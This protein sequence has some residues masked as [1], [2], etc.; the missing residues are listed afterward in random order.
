M[1]WPFNGHAKLKRAWR[2]APQPTH[3]AKRAHMNRSMIRL[4]FLFL[5]A[6]LA[7]P[8]H[9][10]TTTTANDLERS[11]VGCW[12]GQLQYRDYKSGKTYALPLRTEIS[13]INDGV[14]FLKQSVFDEG[15]NRPQV[16]ITTL[17]M[18]NKSGTAITTTGYRAGQDVETDHADVVVDHYTDRSHWSERYTSTG[19]DDNQAAQIRVTVVL[20]G[21]Q[22]VSTKEV[23]PQANPASDWIVR[24]SATVNRQSSCTP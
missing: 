8:S 10:Q 23:K 15:K 19:M 18:F 22:L 16:Y 4:G 11:L 1:P 20:T 13:A 14:T 9:A 2:H 7:L 6:L 5:C 17:S 24:N 3:T 21:D 12:K